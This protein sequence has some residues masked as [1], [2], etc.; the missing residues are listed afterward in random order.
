[1]RRLTHALCAVSAALLAGCMVGPDYQ[2][3]TVE[4][5]LAYDYAEA[6]ALETAALE[7]WKQLDDPVLDALITDSA[8]FDQLPVVLARL[9]AGASDSLCTRIDYP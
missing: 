5:P 7:W 3:P 6:Q 2:R 1:M 9:A 8:P 4:T